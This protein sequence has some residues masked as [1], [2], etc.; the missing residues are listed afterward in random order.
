MTYYLIV[1]LAV[2]G[3]AVNFRLTKCYQNRTGTGFR[4]SVLFNII[5]GAFTAVL[6]YFINGFMNGFAL[7]VTSF[8]W[9]MALL[10]LLFCGGYAL[11]GFKII[12]MGDIAVYTMFLMLGGMMLPY[13]FGLLFLEEA[14]SYWRLIGLM[15]MVVA[16]ALSSREGD[17]KDQKKGSLFFFLLCMI[18]FCLNGGGSIVSKIHQ[19]PKNVDRAVLSP[20]F[21]MMAGIIRVVIF[22]LIYLGIRLHDRRL[23]AERR[24]AP[25]RL[26]VSVIL[27]M[28][29]SS[30]VD[31]ASYLLQLVGASHLPASVLYPMITGG[32]VVLTALAGWLFFK[33]KPSNRAIVGIVLCFVA[34]LLFL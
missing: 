14:F 18:V 24:P 32:S 13:F 20:V 25:V 8:S 5:T 22:S 26:P 1:L 34:T 31:G 30:A 12:A 11:I 3:L 29:A 7:H 16:I 19:L 15:L 17:K 6:F 10:L 4:L 27:I 9:L 23:P 33:Q 21:V 28:L 2:I